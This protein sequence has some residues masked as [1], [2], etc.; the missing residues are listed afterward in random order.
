MHS[1]INLLSVVYYS[2]FCRGDSVTYLE[3][4]LLISFYDTTL[5]FFFFN[6]IGLKVYKLHIS[7]HFNYHIF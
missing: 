1:H 2:V 6:L 7:V 3:K 4:K 5:A